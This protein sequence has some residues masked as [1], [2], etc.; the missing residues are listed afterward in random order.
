MF[1][2]KYNY[3]TRDVGSKFTLD[4]ITRVVDNPTEKTEVCVL[5]G[6]HPSSSYTGNTLWIGSFPEA[7]IPYSLMVAN[8]D[9]SPKREYDITRVGNDDKDKMSLGHARVATDLN[10]ILIV[11]LYKNGLHHTVFLR[12]VGFHKS[13]IPLRNI[14]SCEI[15]KIDSCNDEGYSTIYK[16]DTDEVYL[17][18][19]SES[20]QDRLIEKSQ[21]CTLNKSEWW[22]LH[23]ERLGFLSEPVVCHFDFTS[24]DE[25][26]IDEDFENIYE[27]IDKISK[28]HHK[29]AKRL[30][31][32]NQ[33]E[34]NPF[35]F[36]RTPV[37][38]HYFA[39][40]TVSLKA[41]VLTI[42]APYASQLKLIINE[43]NFFKLG[44]EPLLVFRSETFDEF[45]N[46]VKEEQ[47]GITLDRIFRL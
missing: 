20:V 6:N 22:D 16:H 36:G 14:L 15:L 12:V 7:D 1:P 46:I 21:Y 18:N 35:F 25:P 4:S 30:A 24:K 44:N 37:K 31:S 45:Y 33:L 26:I 28:S 2:R 43:D 27:T 23:L 29:Q 13:E 42:T 5:C 17:K 9:G 10:D 11:G 41:V 40:S 47:T 8:S 39:S 32:T 34:S 38:L 3:K 19:I